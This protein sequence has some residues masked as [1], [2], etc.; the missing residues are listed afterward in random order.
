MLEETHQFFRHVLQ[1][2]RSVRDFLD[3]DYSFVNRSLAD[4]YGVPFEGSEDNEFV[5]V[6]FPLSVKRGGLLGHGSILTLP[7]NGVETSPIERGVWVLADL[8]GTP[9]PPPPKAVP[10][11]TPDLNGAVTVR[12]MLEKHPSDA[13]CMECHR[14]LDPLGFALEAFDPI[15]RYRTKYSKTQPVSTHGNYLGKDFADVTEL[16]QILSSDIRPFARN[17]IIRIAEYAK[18]RKLVA[19]D[20]ST[21]DSIL[22]ASENGDYKLADLVTKIATSDLMTHR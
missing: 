2:N 13:A 21:V 1:E 3:S 7:A 11:L 6:T 5:R 8:L 20:Y 10:A 12:E 4:L 16:K 22:S 18:G 9:P 15:G 17:L 14:R 19:A